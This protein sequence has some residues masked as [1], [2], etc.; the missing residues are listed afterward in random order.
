[1]VITSRHRDT[2]LAIQA[3]ARMSRLRRMLRQQQTRRLELMQAVTDL[4]ARHENLRQLGSIQR[5][6]TVPFQSLHQVTVA[7]NF[8][9]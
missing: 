6:M 4:R 8:E 9:E 1:M 3:N 5:S 7:L 2:H